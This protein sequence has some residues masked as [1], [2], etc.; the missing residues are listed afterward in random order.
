MRLAG[1]DRPGKRG[2]YWDP[3]GRAQPKFLEEPAR[4]LAKEIGAIIKQAFIR[5]AT[6]A[7][8]LLLGGLR[9]Q[10][11]S[12]LLVPVDTGALKNSAFTRLE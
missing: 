1:K 4:R 2:Q 11:E 8:A 10:R 12:Q 9:I 3:Q 6:M 5:G 7:Q